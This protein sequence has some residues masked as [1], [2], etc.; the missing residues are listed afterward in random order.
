MLTNYSNN[1]NKALGLIK[2]ALK[3]DKNN[4]AII[5][6]YGWIL[7]RT[8]D[9]NKALVELKKAF[10]L[11]KDPEI[12]AHIIEVLVTKNEIPE[13]SMLLKEARINYPDNF[14]INELY[15][16]YPLFWK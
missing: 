3:Y 14:Y 1:Y 6:S 5:D 9:Y 7:Y 12:L 13:A 11:Y 15:D 16:K 8:G 10:S 4:P 2:K